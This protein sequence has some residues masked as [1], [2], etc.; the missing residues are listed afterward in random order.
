MWM[1]CLFFI[2]MEG[3]DAMACHA[4]HNQKTNAMPRHSN[5]ETFVSILV[6]AVAVAVAVA[7]AVVVI[8]CLKFRHFNK[9]EQ[10]QYAEYSSYLIEEN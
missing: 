10:I 4:T 5:V 3:N 1:L 7:L 8:L 9:T 2:L 6:A